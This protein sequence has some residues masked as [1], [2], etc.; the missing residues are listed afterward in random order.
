MVNQVFLPIPGADAKCRYICTI[1]EREGQRAEK[2]FYIY[3]LIFFFFFF[4]FRAAPAAYGA[5]QARGQ[6]GATAAGIH[7]S[8][9]QSQILNPLN[10]A[11]DG[12]CVLMDA[13]QIH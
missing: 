10:K 1:G 3:T 11:R 6:T 7:H 5:S 9:W 12:T 13:S 4:F 8:S 2:D